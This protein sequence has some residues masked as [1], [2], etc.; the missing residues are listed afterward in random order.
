VAAVIEPSAPVEVRVEALRLLEDQHA[1]RKEFGDTL[2]LLVADGVAD[3]LR[4]AA[5]Q[6]LLKIDAG[7]AVMVAAQLVGKGTTLEKQVSLAVLSGAQSTAADEVLVQQM[8]L[9]GQG[10]II[11]PIRLDLLE[12]ATARSDA[13]VLLKDK[14]AAY[15]AAGKL[16]PGTIA[17][18]I[19]CL[20]G[21][22]PKL[23]RDLALENLTANCVACHRFESKEGSEVGP[24]LNQI[25]RMI[26]RYHLLEALVNPG[27]RIS[28]GFGMI[29]VTLKDGQTVSGGLV[30]SNASEIQVRIAD[31]TI[32]KI[33]S[34]NVAAK[35]D[36]ISVMPPMSAIL[37]KRQIRDVVAYLSELGK[38]TVKPKKK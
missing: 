11:A 26:D 4:A 1:S 16:Q 34:S 31:G 5:L 35:T 18:F 14:L 36:P 22:D 13:N 2:T 12:A 37:N 23:G 21:G 33:S 15:A 9:L 27:A 7:R 25:G 32:Q 24:A 6:C 3:K 30:L 19:E 20:E 17:G 28:P 10:R 8:D 29:S 38:A